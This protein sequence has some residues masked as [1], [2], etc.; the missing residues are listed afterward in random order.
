MN[1]NQWLE[2]SPS[3]SLS[4]RRGPPTSEHLRSCDLGF[5]VFLCICTNNLWTLW[6]IALFEDLY[7][8]H[9][10]N[11]PFVHHVIEAS[12]EQDSCYKW[13]M[14]SVGGQWTT[15]DDSCCVKS[16]S[17]NSGGWRSEAQG[18]WAPKF[19]Q[20]SWREQSTMHVRKPLDMEGNWTK[21]C[22]CCSMNVVWI[23]VQYV[24]YESLG[25]KKARLVWL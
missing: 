17:W 2:K 8:L 11:P 6:K 3:V 14:I 9:L 10:F 25:L 4:V 24:L 22:C 20:T 19:L 18:L 23:F 16:K 13:G 15:S 1:W 21:I 12:V 7:R 5:L